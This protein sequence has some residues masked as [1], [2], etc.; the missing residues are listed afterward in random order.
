MLL[1]SLAAFAWAF[2]CRDDEYLID[3]RCV[4]KT[5]IG[6]NQLECMGYGECMDGICHCDDGFVLEGTA[7]CMPITCIVDGKMCPNGLCEHHHGAWSCVCN[8]NFTP[9]G[10]RCIPNECVTGTFESGEPEI[11]HSRGTCD[12]DN[13]IC[14]CSPLYKGFHC[15]ECSEIS[16]MLDGDRCYPYVCVHEDRSG[17]HSICGGHGQCVRYDASSRPEDFFYICRCDQGYLSILADNCVIGSCVSPQHLTK[18]CTGH[19]ACEDDKCVCEEGY[20][21]EYCEI[22]EEN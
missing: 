13:K 22:R 5:C 2:E 3:G 18:E 6:F 19:G 1:L 16:E 12:I 11:C 8:T 17:K 14:Q 4:K 20:S 15:T 9:S 21:G 7:T 10:G